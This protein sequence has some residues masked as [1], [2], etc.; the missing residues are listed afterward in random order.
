M[1]GG[2]FAR[3][4]SGRAGASGANAR[5]I[6][7][8]AAT[9]RDPAAILTRHYPDEVREAEDYRDLREQLE[10]YC[11]QEEAYELSR[12]QRGG[13]GPV[14]THYRGVL[15]FEGEVGTERARGLAEDYLE[16]AFPEARAIAAVHQDTEHTHVHLHVQARNV[17]DRKLHF[18]R[19]AYGRLDEA[20]AELY[21]RE[22]GP[23]K[24]EEHLA[25]KAE[26]R[27]WKRDYAQ[28][29]ANGHEPPEAPDRVAYRPRPG[30][31]ADREEH[32]YGAEQ[33]RAGGDQRGLAA[34]DPRADGR[35]DGAAGG[36]RALAEYAGERDSAVQGAERAVHGADRATGE[37]RGALRAAQ[38]FADR[39]PGRARVDDEP[40]RDR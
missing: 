29:R 1:A 25:K 21:A 36:E 40:E 3:F 8:G 17:D 28:A 7:R 35:G 27:A 13:H 34:A 5:Y 6:T 32:G 20:W 11:A 33:A 24:L 37:A 15:S 23:A 39:A 38:D 2:V 14:R 4:G 16:R 9:G 26:T 18:D 19:G 10:E 22:F 12:P 31:L 30:E